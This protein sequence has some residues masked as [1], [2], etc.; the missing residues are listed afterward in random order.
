[1]TIEQLAHDV[2]HTRANVAGLQA[3]LDVRVNAF[4]RS[5]EGIRQ[6]ME[7]AKLARASSEK[8]MR[9][10]ILE[11]YKSTGEKKQPGGGIRMMP[12]LEYKDA[13]ALFWAQQHSM[14]LALDRKAFE[15]LAKAGDVSATIVTVT[16]EPQATIDSDLSRFLEMT[17]EEVIDRR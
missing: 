8:W 2:A 7:T 17:T 15:R 3:E 1:M 16:Q 6:Q 5:I 14:A 4:E 9:D 12:H 10:A 13:D 11:A